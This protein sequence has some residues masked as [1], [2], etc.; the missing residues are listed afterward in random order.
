MDKQEEKIIL[1]F[2]NRIPPD[3]SCHVKKVIVFGSRARGDAQKDSDFD[4]LVLVD[5]KNSALEEILNDAA[6][7]V[8]WD[9]FFTPILSL[10]IMTQ[11]HFEEFLQKGYSFYR[12]VEKEGIPV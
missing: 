4:V 6:Y 7:Q 11:T 9:A 10:K 12:N 3:I 2:K 8:M 1:D 5:E